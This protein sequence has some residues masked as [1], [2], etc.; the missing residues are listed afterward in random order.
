MHCVLEVR[1]GDLMVY[2]ESQ[3]KQFHSFLVRANRYPSLQVGGVSGCGLQ[4]DKKIVIVEV[5]VIAVHFRV[6]S[7][8]PFFRIFQMPFSEMLTNFMTF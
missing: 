3:T 7:H 4:P 1:P 8:W 5:S 6:K 2:A